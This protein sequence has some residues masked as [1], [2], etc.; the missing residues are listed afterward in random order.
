MPKAWPRK[1][2]DMLEEISVNLLRGDF[3]KVVSVSQEAAQ[4]FDS[5]GSE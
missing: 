5:A 3:K 2:N 1:L 4:M